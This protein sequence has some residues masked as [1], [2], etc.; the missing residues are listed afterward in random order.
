[1]GR[2]YIQRNDRIAEKSFTKI[3]IVNDFVGNSLKFTAKILEV[4]LLFIYRLYICINLFI[5]RR[6]ILLYLNI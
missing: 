6:S 5:S 2:K 1:N 3:Q 4:H